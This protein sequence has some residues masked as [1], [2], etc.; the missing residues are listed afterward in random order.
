MTEPDSDERLRAAFRSQPEADAGPLPDDLQEQIWLAVSGGLDPDQRRALVDRTASDPA[1][2]EAWRVADALWQARLEGESDALS[3]A[4]GARV[5]PMAPRRPRLWTAP[6]LAAAAT[7]VLVSA[8]VSLQYWRSAPSGDEF[9]VA[10]DAAVE[11]LVASGTA[12]SRDEFRLR[13]TAGPDGAR[14]RLRVTTED[15]RPLVAIGELT[16]PDFTVQPASLADLPPGATVLWQVEMSLPTGQVITSPT[17]D[18]R[19][20]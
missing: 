17:F 19:V 7:L 9:R 13:W 15:L 1:A 3:P 8:V 5:V 4:R 20:R 14:Y 12:L 18:V 16:A 6:W 2:A 10:P 11:S